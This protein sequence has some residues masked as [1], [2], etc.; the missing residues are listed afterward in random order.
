M[1]PSFIALFAI[2]LATLL[3]SASFGQTHESPDM[4]R[5]HRLYQGVTFYIDN[6]DG[7]AFDVELDVRDLNLY[8]QGPREILFKVYDPD[9]R[10]VVREYLPDDGVT[11][12]AYLPI[13]GG[14]DHELQ[15]YSMCRAHGLE[16]MISWSAYSD[17]ARLGTIKA[18]TFK[19]SVPG[20]K[21][22]VYRLLLVGDRD[23]YVT[24]RTSPDLPRGVCGHVSFIHGHGDLFKTRW[25]YVPRGTTGLHLAMAQPDAP[26]ERTYTITAPDG[27]VIATGSATG[28][29][30]EGRVKFK[31]GEYDDQVLRLDVSDGDTDYALRVQLTRKRKAYAGFGSPAVL[32]PDA[33]TAKATRGGAIY[34]GDE[35]FWH[36]W[37]VRFENWMANHQADESVQPLLDHLRGEFRKIGPGDGR[38]AAGWSNWAYAMGYYDFK[39]WRQAWLLSKNSKTPADVKAI[40]NEACLMVADR[41][42]FALDLE[43]VNGN[44]FAQTN[45]RLWYATKITGDPLITERYNLWFDRWLTGGWGPG[46]GM[47][48]SGTSQEH[49]AHDANYGTYIIDNWLGKAGG[50]GTWVEHGILDDT[51]DPRFK[52]AF[53]RVVNWLSYVYCSEHQ[54]DAYA[55]NARIH[56]GPHSLIRS[57]DRILKPKS[58]PGPDLTVS[59]NDGDEF[60]AA[61]RKHYYVSTFHGRLAPQFSSETFWGQIGFGGGV[62]LQVTVPG[63]GTVINST[64]SDSYGKKMHISE[65]RNFHVHGIAGVTWDG[66]PFHGGIGE[67][68]DA[69]LDGNV[70]TSSGPIRNRNLRSSRRYEFKDDRILCQVSLADPGDKALRTLW[71]GGRLYGEIDEAYEIIPFTKAKVT[72][73]DGESNTIG[74]LSDTPTEA[75]TIVLARDGFGARITLD[76]ARRVSAG[77]NDTVMIELVAAGG[78][79]SPSKAASIEYDIVPYV[80]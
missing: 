18:R 43:R 69:K 5:T 74:P 6:A 39:V 63:K 76:R 9:G 33:D 51:D 23:H 78:N 55:F 80:D 26:G 42:S 49:F 28:G 34:V 1:K 75:S 14:W 24:V 38:D 64:P 53:D 7:K 11:S 56:G 50:G 57:M 3:T 13:I 79:P 47:S 54:V 16:P 20:G 44:A 32:C 59:V 31:A 4:Q 19:R 41:S 36:P 77:V 70:V 17:P 73:L 27:T 65:W 66:L 40:I 10:A 68:L 61:R 37:Q 46:A 35:V 25:F 30:A 60:F 15:Y 21:K 8:G 52:Q 45:V 62:I 58:D 72:L 22:G 12:K 48:K 71:S 29:F 67:H 2:C